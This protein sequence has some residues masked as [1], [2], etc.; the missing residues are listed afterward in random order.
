MSQVQRLVQLESELLVEVK[1]TLMTNLV[2]ISG[3]NNCSEKPIEMFALASLSIASTTNES[4][5]ATT[6]RV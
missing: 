2:A 6:T 5:A 3:S 1:G 4:T